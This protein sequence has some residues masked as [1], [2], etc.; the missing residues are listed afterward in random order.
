TAPGALWGVL[1][2]PSLYYGH[3][4]RMVLVT[5]AFVVFGVA[6]ATVRK[7]AIR[8]AVWLIVIAGIVFQAI[9]FSAPPAHST[10]LYRYMWDGQVQAAGIDPDLYPASAARA[11]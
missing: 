9:G 7:V 6:A 2:H 4:A 8:A 3:V 5:A 1:S 11:R 10:D